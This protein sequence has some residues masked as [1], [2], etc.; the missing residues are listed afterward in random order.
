MTLGET[1]S[2]VNR[3]LETKVLEITV[4]LYYIVTI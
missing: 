3:R 4:G 2:Y 1:Q